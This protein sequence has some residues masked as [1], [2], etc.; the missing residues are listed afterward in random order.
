MTPLGNID[1][2]DV[3]PNAKSDLLGILLFFFFDK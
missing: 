2:R 3:L 1:N